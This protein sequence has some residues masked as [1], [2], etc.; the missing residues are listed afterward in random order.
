MLFFMFMKPF[1]VGSTRLKNLKTT[2]CF[3]LGIPL[4]FS[5]L[6]CHFD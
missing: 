3:D 1:I 4:Q 5:A 2:V 6:F